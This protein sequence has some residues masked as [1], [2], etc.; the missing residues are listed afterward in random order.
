MKLPYCRNCGTKVEEETNY[1]P[2][3][4]LQISKNVEDETAFER[5]GS[6]SKLQDHWIRRVIAIFIDSIIVGIGAWI[7]TAIIFI[8][9]LFS[10]NWFTYWTVP[11]N[12][13]QFPFVMGFIY[14]LYFTIIEYLYGFTVGKK[15]MGLRVMSID[16]NKLTLEKSFIRNISKIYWI[17]LLLDVIGGFLTKGNPRQK[18]TDRIAGTLII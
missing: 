15:L 10:S 3:C 5:L 9:L 4:G 12:W 2:K 16:D 17:F 8:P 7:I 1:C 11:W 6:D 14:V 13:L 18:Y